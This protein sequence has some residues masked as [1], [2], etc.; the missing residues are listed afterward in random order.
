MLHTHFITVFS[1]L[2]PQ[3][4]EGYRL[5]GAFKE[6]MLQLLEEEVAGSTIIGGDVYMIVIWRFDISSQ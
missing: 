3:I 1:F 2:R 6:I 4:A 5:N